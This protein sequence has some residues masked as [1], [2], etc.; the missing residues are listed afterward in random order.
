M[1]AEKILLRRR[2]EGKTDY[3]ARLALLKSG[4]PRIVIRKTNKYMIVE[5]VKSE[6][7][8]D[9]VIAYVNSKELKKYGWQHS[10]KNLPAAYL[11]GMLIAKKSIN[12]GIK[13]AIA[14]F[15]L[16]RSTKGSR[17]FA[18]IA[19]AIANRLKIPCNK[20]MLPTEERISGKHINDA[21]VSSF[22]KIKKQ[23]EKIE[24]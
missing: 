21:V 19:G 5:I 13:E 2:R 6:E 15:G 24:K 3:K 11:T 4:I 16:S 1:K 12:K 23:L 7:A 9:F 14:D 10:L 20:E 17:I 8:Q 22:E 18:V